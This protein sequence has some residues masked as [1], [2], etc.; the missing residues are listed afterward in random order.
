LIFVIGEVL[1]D[2]FPDYRRIGGAPFNFAFHLKQMGFPLHFISRVG[3]D[4]N[5]KAILNQMK[6]FRFDIND[7]QVDPAHQ[8]GK[9]M[10][11]LDN[12]GVPDFNIL[13]DVAFDHI[14]FNEDMERALNT[15]PA[16]LYFGTLFQRG[17]NG[18]QLMQRIAKYKQDQTRF[19][20]D[21]NLR[22]G[23][24]D[25]KTVWS[26][27]TH[28]D[29]L[30]LNMEELTILA[31]MFDLSGNTSSIITDLM[32]VFNLIMVALTKGEKGSEIF[33]PEFHSRANNPEQYKAVDTVGAGDAFA[34]VLAAGYLKQKSLGTTLSAASAF[35][36]QICT[37]K[38]AITDDHEFYINV[39]QFIHKR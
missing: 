31:D 24:Y 2:I 37:I 28:A 39:N 29:I 22:P 12:D 21:I 27:L 6:R 13:P 10:V 16:L 9:V 18:G 11:T 17:K 25:K 7:I 1:F 33:T 35:A 5:G 19:F 15:P 23:C 32:D 3:I 38:G 30:K 34:A 20:Y 4:G 14:E 8:T 36:G 26:S